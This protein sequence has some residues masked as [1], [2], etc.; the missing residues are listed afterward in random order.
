EKL[1]A[2]IMRRKAAL[3][4]LRT[5]HEQVWR[6]CFDYSFPERGDGFFCET[7]DAS[8]LQAK[9]AKLFDSTATDAGQIL[10]SG[11][12]GGG[13]PSNSRWFGM[14]AGGDSDEEKRFFDESAE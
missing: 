9:R 5:P 8:A 13:T 6:D 10:A 7:N 3:Q 4:A 12:M 2:Q 14:S 1:A 11:M